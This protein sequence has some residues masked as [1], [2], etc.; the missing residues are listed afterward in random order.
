[1][2]EQ[3]VLS[4]DL[5]VRSDTVLREYWIIHEIHMLGMFTNKHVILLNLIKQKLKECYIN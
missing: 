5:M 3:A 4:P 2:D 1:M